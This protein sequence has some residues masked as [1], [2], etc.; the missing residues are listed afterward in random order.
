MMRTSETGAKLIADAGPLVGKSLQYFHIDSWELGKPTW[1]PKMRKFSGG[2]VTIRCRGCRP[3]WDRL[4]TMPPRPAGS[5]KTIAAPP[6]TWWRPTTT[7]A[8]RDFDGQR[9]PAARTPN[10]AGRSLRIGSTAQCLGI[11]DVPMGEFWKRNHEPDGG[12]TIT[13]NPSLKQ[14]ASAMH[15][16]GKRSH[17]EAYT[18]FGCDWIDDPWTMKDIG[19]AAFCEGLSRNVLCFWVHQS[20][21]DAQPGFQWAHV[22][23]HF[24]CNLTW[25]PMSGAPG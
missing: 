5:C 11:N 16:Y 21:L 8:C 9:R 15:I 12:I 3:S 13:H 24:D 25:W 14:A 2:A 17:A 20:R 23:T 10:R 7:A 4:S 18:S 6:P 1:T 22:G 19:D